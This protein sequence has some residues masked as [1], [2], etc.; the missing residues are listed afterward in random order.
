MGGGA[1][2]AELFVQGK[3][4]RTRTRNHTDKRKQC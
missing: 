1:P 2:V 3:E 4:K